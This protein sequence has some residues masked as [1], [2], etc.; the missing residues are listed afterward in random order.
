MKLVISSLI[1][2]S[3]AI[4]A[5]AEDFVP[6]KL[7]RYDKLM[8]LTD[9][10]RGAYLSELQ[11]FAID[12]EESG[13]TASTT[14]VPGESFSVHSSFEF[15]LLNQALA[16]ENSS[17]FPPCAEL[18]SDDSD[19]NEAQRDLITR[20]HTRCDKGGNFICLVKKIDT[21]KVAHLVCS[22]LAE[23]YKKLSAEHSCAVGTR[24]CRSPLFIA[25]NAS[26]Q[27]G[28]APPLCVPNDGRSIGEACQ[29]RSKNPREIGEYLKLHPN[30]YTKDYNQFAK[31]IEWYCKAD[32]SHRHDF[33]KQDCDD[34]NAR[35]EAA[36]KAPEK[37]P[38]TSEESTKNV[39]GTFSGTPSNECKANIKSISGAFKVT[40]RETKGLGPK[41]ILETTPPG[42]WVESECLLNGTLSNAFYGGSQNT[43]QQTSRKDADNRIRLC[44]A[45]LV[46]NTEGFISG[47]PRVFETLKFGPKCE[48]LQTIY[49]SIPKTNGVCEETFQTHPAAGSI[50]VEVKKSNGKAKGY[51]SLMANGA[52]DSTRF[53]LDSNGLGIGS[54]DFSGKLYA[55]LHVE[56]DRCTLVVRTYLESFKDGQNGSADET[57]SEP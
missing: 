3:S 43:P 28:L 20:G 53:D 2:I 31:E 27:P 30:A 37:A 39:P 4:V 51:I 56:Q 17:P 7:L 11:N 13:K 46:P 19:W 10:Q 5:K 16:Q 35:L 29:S 36:K 15:A 24:Y 40:S 55:S 33:D 52:T 23:D 38:G 8:R 47:S 41:Y 12:L 22:N 1:L 26:E 45:H 48:I 25:K 32:G 18:H 14:N 6:L 50:K 34:L 57:P 21:D 42:N 44:L 9:T 49:Y 54:R